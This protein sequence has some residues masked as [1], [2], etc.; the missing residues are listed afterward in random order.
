[1][2]PKDCRD[3]RFIWIE[4]VSQSLIVGQLKQFAELAGAESV[5]I[6]AYGFGRWE[7]GSTGLHLAGDDEK[8]IMH[9]HGGAYVVG[10]SNPFFEV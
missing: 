7:T 2:S 5:R 6:P 1:V 8:I 9:L 3:A 10:L 4:A